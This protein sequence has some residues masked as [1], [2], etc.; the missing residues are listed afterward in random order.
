MAL[1]VRIRRACHIAG[2]AT[3]T[4][5]HRRLP[6][7]NEELKKRLTAVARPGAGYRAAWDALRNEFAPLN[8]KRVYRLWKELRLNLKVR[9]KKRRTGMTVP[10]KATRPNEVWSLDFCFDNC[11]NGTKL[12]ILAVIDEFTRE[13]L[14]LEARTSIKSV[15]V[16]KVLS[17]LF[18][19]RDAP[20]FVRSDNGPEFIANS[21]SIWLRLNGSRSW[22]IRPGRP[23]QNGHAESFISRLR[24]E[25]LNA[26]AFL[27]LAEAQV[28]LRQFQRFYNQD[29]GHS[30]LG[31]A[32]PE[33]FFKSFSKNSDVG[34]P[35][36]ILS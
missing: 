11:M 5:Y 35:N 20:T 22:F 26:E 36:V 28:R 24:A 15:S 29:R 12:K 9:M 1:G 6:D 31:Y 4:L 17:E 3:S 16:R 14:A 27:G 33:R 13:C 23:W 7:R 10:C 8:P 25:C 21:L 32:T 18:E 2:I 30:A 34:D 19:T